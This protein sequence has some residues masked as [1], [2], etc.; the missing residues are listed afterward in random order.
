MGVLALLERTRSASYQMPLLDALLDYIPTAEVD[1]ETGT[2]VVTNPPQPHSGGGSG[3]GDGDDDDDAPPPPLSAD[4][5]CRALI[6]CLVGIIST[7]YS[8]DDDSSGQKKKNPRDGGIGNGNDS[9]EVMQEHCLRVEALLEVAIEGHEQAREMLYEH[10]SELLSSPT[11]S[12]HVDGHGHSFALG[13]APAADKDADE[14][15]AGGVGGGGGGGL[16]AD[17][18]M[19]MALDQELNGPPG[20]H[21]QPVVQRPLRC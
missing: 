2:Y 1:P 3:G 9:P 20:N 17:A 6:P 21:H 5:V 13:T 7:V 11:Y 8:G 10:L 18:R 19:A 15:G 4:F 14:G 12:R 16:S